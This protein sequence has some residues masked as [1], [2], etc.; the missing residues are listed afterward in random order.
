MLIT[1]LYSV[2]KLA[3]NQ[4][5]RANIATTYGADISLSSPL[6]NWVTLE[7]RGGI[8]AKAKRNINYSHTIP[9]LIFFVASILSLCFEGSLCGRK[10]YEVK[11]YLMQ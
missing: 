4:N 2:H 6:V 7:S 10:V 9:W 8:Y 11:Y 5:H 3:L 1:R